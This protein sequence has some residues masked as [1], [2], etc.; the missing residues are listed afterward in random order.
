MQVIR[1]SLKLKLQVI[2]TYSPPSNE[3]KDNKYP[4]YYNNEFLKKKTKMV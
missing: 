2:P 4:L 3:I 1:I